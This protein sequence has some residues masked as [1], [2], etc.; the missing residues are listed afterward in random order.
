MPKYAHEI[1]VCKGKGRKKVGKTIWK[2]ISVL[3]LLKDI[4]HFFMLNAI[5][6]HCGEGGVCRIRWQLMGLRKLLF[7]TRLQQKKSRN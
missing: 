5:L 1:G 3:V 2:P 4:L 7:K 6:G